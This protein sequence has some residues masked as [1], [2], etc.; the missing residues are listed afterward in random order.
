MIHYL[1]A[2]VESSAGCVVFF[3]MLMITMFTNY[4]LDECF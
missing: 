1:C 2:L 4:F 3:S